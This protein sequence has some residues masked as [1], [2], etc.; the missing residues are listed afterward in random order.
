M[1]SAA[2]QRQLKKSRVA[3]YEIT[4][5]SSDSEKVIKTIG[6]KPLRLFGPKM[7]LVASTDHLVDLSSDEDPSSSDHDSAVD[8]GNA[9]RVESGD[10]DISPG[11]AASAS[12]TAPQNRTGAVLTPRSATGSYGPDNET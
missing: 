7:N 11:A 3:F 8:W 5:K 6:N 9:P 2:G 10:E 1:I 12:A 4:T